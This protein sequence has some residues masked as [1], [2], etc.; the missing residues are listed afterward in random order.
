[1]SSRLSLS[2]LLL[3]VVLLA[4]V[5]VYLN[6]P[7]EESKQN[8]GARATPVKTGV[9]SS[10]AFPITIES[11]GTATANE[12]VNVTAQ[13]TDTVKAINFNDGK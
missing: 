11:L 1:M 7:Q 3:G 8:A 6:M 2:P 9:V 10:Q 13:V 5:V 4:G 12:S